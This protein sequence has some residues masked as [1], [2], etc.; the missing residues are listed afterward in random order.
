MVRTSQ[1]RG[2]AAAL[3]RVRVRCARITGIALV[4]VVVVVVIDTTTAAATT[5]AVVKV[6]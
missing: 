2:G 1:S 6:S 5:A 4:V 3:V